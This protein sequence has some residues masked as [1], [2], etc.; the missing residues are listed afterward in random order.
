[1]AVFDKQILERLHEEF[2]DNAEITSGHSQT[3][4]VIQNRGN[5]KKILA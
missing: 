4:V 2:D 1:V 5:M 3:G